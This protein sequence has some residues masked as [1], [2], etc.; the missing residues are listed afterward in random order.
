MLRD[1]LYREEYEKQGII[2]FGK[3]QFLH[4]GGE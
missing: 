1:G 4:G 3:K 2:P